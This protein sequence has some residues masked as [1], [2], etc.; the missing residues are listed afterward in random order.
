[1][2]ATS[3]KTSFPM[4]A[5]ATPIASRNHNAARRL[6]PQGRRFRRFSWGCARHWVAREKANCWRSLHPPFRPQGGPGRNSPAPPSPRGTQPP[7]G[8]ADTPKNKPHRSRRKLYDRTSL[9]RVNQHQAV[10]GLQPFGAISIAYGL[11]VRRS[12]SS[13]F[14]R[15][16]ATGIAGRTMRESENLEEVLL[17]EEK[18]GSGVN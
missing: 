4:L 13:I 3:P 17:I 8:A 15:R 1:M 12:R 2:Y 11:M 14:L 7:S 6:T 5:A 16:A 18:R 10:S 9:N